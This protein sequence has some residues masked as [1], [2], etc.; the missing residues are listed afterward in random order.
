ML[1]VP[2]IL[3]KYMKL[4]GGAVDCLDRRYSSTIL[5]GI[6]SQT[7]IVIIFVNT[8]IFTVRIFSVERYSLK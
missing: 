6:A 1:P 2:N 7:T 3:M 4:N 8:L 5:H